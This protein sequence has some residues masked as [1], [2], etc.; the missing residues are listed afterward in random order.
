MI[1]KE[2][3]NKIR[4]LLIV[5]AVI[6]TPISLNLF[7]FSWSWP[8]VLNGTL[9]EW[10]SFFGSYSGGVVGGIVAYIVSKAQ[11]DNQRT[12]ERLK[13]LEA[14]LPTYVAMKLEFDKVIQTVDALIKVK[15]KM[16][17]STDEKLKEKI[18]F[19][20]IGLNEFHW[21]RWER[22][23]LITDSILLEELLKFQESFQR[24]IEVFGIDIEGAEKEIIDKYEKGLI[25]KEQEEIDKLGLE[26]MKA[27][28][29]H[30]WNELDYC[31]EKA[32]KINAVL[33]RKEN[34]IKKLKAGFININRTNLDTHYEDYKVNR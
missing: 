24:T 26:G 27:E 33:L 29:I 30:Y 25:T 22:K 11:I 4:K 19:A 28:K 3:T 1:F 2:N 21:D 12:M 20:S 34:L 6:G 32:S 5:V 15:E 18:Y 14:E 7:V 17:S 31:K 13:S 10:I 8:K 9:T 16:D 23:W